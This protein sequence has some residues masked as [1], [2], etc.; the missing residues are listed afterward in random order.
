LAA[1]WLML[2]SYYK[3]QAAASFGISCLQEQNMS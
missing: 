2:V 1:A 3:L